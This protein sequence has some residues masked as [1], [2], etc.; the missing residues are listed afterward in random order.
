[1]PFKEQHYSDIILSVITAFTGIA[2]TLD[3]IEQ[4][5]R[6]LLLLISI[7]SGLLIIVTNFSK[8][9]NKIKSYF[10]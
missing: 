2:S 3:N 9:W 8:A 1:M 6:L 7:I 5:M 4:I 10:K